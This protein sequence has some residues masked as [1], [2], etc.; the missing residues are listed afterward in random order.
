MSVP[1]VF[2]DRDGTIN[3]DHGYVYRWNDFHF[4]PGAIEGLK[5][6]LALGFA[7]A[8]VSNQSGIARGL[9]QTADVRQLHLRMKDELMALG[10]PLAAIVY[11]P[12]GEEEQCECRK[13]ATGMADEVQRQLDDEIDFARSWTIGDKFSDIEFGKSLGTRTVLLGSKYWNLS[14]LNDERRPDLIA[15][16]LSEAAQSIRSAMLLH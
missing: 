9:Y 11:C 7:L 5:H 3:I 1:I 6:L 8:V 13:P 14:R 2:L 4:A 10:I 12:H 15:A 16:D